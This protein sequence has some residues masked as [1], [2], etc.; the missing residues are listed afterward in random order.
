MNKLK[1]FLTEYLDIS[2]PYMLQEERTKKE[3]QW[4][5]ACEKYSEYIKD[6]ENIFSKSFLKIY[7]NGG[8]HDYKIDSI[9]FKFE[10]DKNRL[11][12]VV[13]LESSKKTFSFICKDVRNFFSSF[14][15]E[16]D[17]ITPNYYLYGEY[18]KDEN[19]LWH[20]NF[21][22]GDLYEINITSKDFI[23][24]IGDVSEP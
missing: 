22:F 3:N 19:K 18:Y 21:L 8:F 7:K 6:N 24:K 10:E 16:K 14:E 17:S 1:Y 23:F 12:I 13:N 9:N 2:S 20:H 11:D 5:I 4:E 15:Y